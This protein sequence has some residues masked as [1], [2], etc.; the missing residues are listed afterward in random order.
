MNAKLANAIAD[1]KAA[2]KPH[3]FKAALG[4]GAVVLSAGSLVAQTPADPYTAALTTVQGIVPNT[5]I[6]AFWA[7]IAGLALGVWAIALVV[8]AFMGASA[9]KMRSR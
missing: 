1:A 5:A 4:I 7:A 3:R 8:K 2:I 9:G 6:Y